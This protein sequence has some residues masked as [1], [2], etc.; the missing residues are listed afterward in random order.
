MFKDKL[1]IFISDN[2]V[3][4]YTAVGKLR[5]I[6]PAEIRAKLKDQ[7]H[8]G[9]IRANQR[10]GFTA[11]YDKK[12]AAFYKVAL[13]GC[14][15]QYVAAQ[16]NNDLDI[17]V[18]VSLAVEN[19]NNKHTDVHTTHMFNKFEIQSSHLPKQQNYLVCIIAQSCRICK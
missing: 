16:R 11:V 3:L 12:L 18:K 5:I 2:V 9:I 8:I 15:N 14:G 4:Q 17:A 19:R 6:I 1:R 13:I 10:M 7:Q